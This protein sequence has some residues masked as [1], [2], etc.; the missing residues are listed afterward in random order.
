M[1]VPGASCRPIQAPV[2]NRRR[3]A[4][5]RP[6]PRRPP[7]RDSLSAQRVQPCRPGRHPGS[8][9][10]SA[11]MA[12]GVSARQPRVEQ[13]LRDPP[14]VPQTHQDDDRHR[15]GRH[16]RA[17]S[18]RNASGAC[19][20]TTVNPAVDPAVRHRNPGEPGC[21]H[22]SMT[23]PGSPRTA[24]RPRRAPAPLRRRVRAGT[25][26]HSSVAPRACRAGRSG[27]SA[28]AI[29]SCVTASDVR[30]AFA[31]LKCWARVAS[32]T[33][34]SRHNEPSYSTRSASASRR[35]PPFTVSRS[36][37]PGPAADQGDES[38][39]HGR[40]HRVRLASVMVSPRL[41]PL[42]Y[43]VV[44]AS[45]RQA[46]AL[47]SRTTRSMRIKQLRPPR[48]HRRA[49]LPPARRSRS[50]SLEPPSRSASGAEWHPVLPAAARRSPA[51]GHR[52]RS[53][54]SSPARRTTPPR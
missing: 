31:T 8:R 24:P 42:G 13:R 16:A 49:I 48:R 28:G 4:A 36:G 51:L 41:R 30:R 23:P 29:V 33:V 47:P 2:G 18:A 12:A 45:G 9:L 32:A 40:C 1:I 15:S 5:F 39:G 3:I 38:A 35:A 22:G 26:R 46:V 19:P 17:E 43:H 6:A 37:S 10:P 21:G 27:S 7:A 50:D 52:S 20:E 11:P 25:D 44:F 54:A 14:A 34:A 53:R